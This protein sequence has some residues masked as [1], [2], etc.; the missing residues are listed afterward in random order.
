[1]KVLATYSIK[2]GVGKTT[3]AVNLADQAAHAGWRVLLWDLDPQGAATFFLRVKA[4]VKGGAGKL[5]GPR[6]LVEPHLRATDVPGVHLLPA[7]LSLR[8]LDVLLDPHGAGRLRQLLTPVADRYD[9]AIL[10]CPPGI[11]LTSESIFGAADAL[12]VPTVPATLSARTLEQLDDFLRAWPGAPTVLPF[13]AMVDR[14]RR[15]HRELATALTTA[16]PSLLHSVI[17]NSAAVERM[18]VERAPLSAFAPRG[19]ATI[20]YRDLWTET[21]HHVTSVGGVE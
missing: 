4:K 7:D 21:A 20:A 6:G 15:L 3:S 17:P 10:D 12:L 9:V 16:W 8:H 2:G 5:I 11:T 19:V 14:R 13:L 1:M 18:G